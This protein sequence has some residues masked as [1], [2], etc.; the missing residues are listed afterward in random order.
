MP[1]RRP[2]GLQILALALIRGYQRFL[3]PRKG[4][5]CAYRVHRRHAAG[6]SALGYRAIRRLGVWRGLGVL[7]LRLAACGDLHRRCQAEMAE[8]AGVAGSGRRPLAAQRGDCDCGCDLGDLG[9]CNS[10]D[11]SDGSRIF[12]R[13]IDGCSCCDCGCDG[14]GR[15]RKK[16]PSKPSWRYRKRLPRDRDR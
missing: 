3:S 8:V 4:F 14:W 11:A 16:P 13:L 10:C 7:R 1:S 5:V 6:C 15:D 12:S 9:G 2:G